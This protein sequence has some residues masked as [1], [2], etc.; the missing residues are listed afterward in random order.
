MEYIAGGT[1]APRVTVT[2]KGTAAVLLI[3]ATTIRPLK[4]TDRLLPLCWLMSSIK[5]MI[6]NNFLSDTS[7][8]DSSVGFSPLGT[9]LTRNFS[10]KGRFLLTNPYTVF[11]G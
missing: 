11:L 2:V 7:E 3:R 5:T 9:Y 4:G 1:F 8:P 10:Q 6:L